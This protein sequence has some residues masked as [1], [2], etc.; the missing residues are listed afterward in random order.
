MAVNVLNKCDR[1]A[2][3]C[4]TMARNEVE[5]TRGGGEICCKSHVKSKRRKQELT[6]M[7]FA[8]I[9]CRDSIGSG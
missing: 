5:S 1:E 9:N 8:H 3:S 2:P 6:H 4:E 7:G